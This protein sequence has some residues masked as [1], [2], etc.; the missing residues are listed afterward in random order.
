M[1]GRILSKALIA[2]DASN[3][4]PVETTVDASRDLGLL[5][6]RQYLKTIQIGYAT[7]YA[8]GNGESR[9]K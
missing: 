7:Y 2:A 3:L 5:V 8:E 1:D 6:W 9:L 4:K